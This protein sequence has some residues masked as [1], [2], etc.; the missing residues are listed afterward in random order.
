LIILPVLHQKNKERGRR[1]KKKE[2]GA[3]YVLP[4][5]LQQVDLEV[6]LCCSFEI[7][8]IL[9]YTICGSILK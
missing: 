5:V 9:I 7:S 4:T 3:K 8:S 1:R 2:I 6:S